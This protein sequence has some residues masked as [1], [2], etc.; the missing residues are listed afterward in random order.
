M[1]SYLITKRLKGYLIQ[2]VAGPCKIGLERIESDDPSIESV[3]RQLGVPQDQ[4]AVVLKDVRS[5]GAGTVT[6][7]AKP[8]EPLTTV[9]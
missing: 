7:A 8:M 1:T 3:L 9:S 2:C 5:K 4:R 6:F